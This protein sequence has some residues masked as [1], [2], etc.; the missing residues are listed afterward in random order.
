MYL[1]DKDKIIK[2]PRKIQELYQKIKRNAKKKA[3]LIKNQPKNW[4]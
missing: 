2:I 4:V 3:Y 1:R